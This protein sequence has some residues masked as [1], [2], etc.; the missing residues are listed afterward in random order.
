VNGKPG[1]RNSIS[2]WGGGDDGKEFK[3]QV[4]IAQK[5]GYLAPDAAADLLSH[6]RS[7][8]AMLS[9]LIKRLKVNKSNE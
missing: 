2:F 5:I 1:E 6:A 9:T 3:T 8:A 7:I 4:Y